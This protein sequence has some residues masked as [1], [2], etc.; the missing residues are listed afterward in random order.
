MQNFMEELANSLEDSKKGNS[1][2]KCI[3]SRWNNLMK[4]D[5]ILYDTRV[6]TKYR[7]EMLIKRN[8]ILQEYA[9]NTKEL[10]E[11]YYIYNTSA[12]EKTFYDLYSCEEAK[13]HEVITKQI[14]ELPED[15]DLGSVLR[16]KG[17]EFVLDREATKA[18]RKEINIMIKE[19]IEEQSQYLDSRR[20]DGHVY[21]AGEKYLER[22]CLYDLSSTTDGRIEEFEE[23][24]FPKDLYETAK[25]G[26]LF[27]YKNGKYEKHIQ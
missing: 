16:R 6:I 10:G 18:V 14:E 7:D 26:D 8:N 22:I 27:V 1:E 9:K 2:I 15:V 25:E 3:D 17:E 24:E 19:K 13:S 11:M 5:L 23:I 12:N 4:N 20:I 21:E